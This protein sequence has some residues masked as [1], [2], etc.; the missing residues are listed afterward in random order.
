MACAGKTKKYTDQP[1]WFDPLGPSSIDPKT[2]KQT[3]KPSG[4]VEQRQQIFDRLNAVSP[5]VESASAR[6]VSGLQQAAADPGW[7]EAADL[8]RRTIAGDYLEG[9]PQLDAAM[10]QMRRA[11]GAQAANTAAQLQGQYARAGMDFS[12]AHQQAQQANRAAATAATDTAE[13]QARLQ[14][15][16]SERANQQAGAEMLQKAQAA[17]LEY[18]AAV[19]QAYYAPMGQQAE[20][21]TGLS[22]GGQ[23]ATPSSTMVKQPGAFDYAAVVANTAASAAP[24][25]V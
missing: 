6:T 12:T 21:V 18:L 17:P 9:S 23:V 25:S 8:A 20:I 22:G 3:F 15:Y 10:S 4:A 13:T 11:S 24:D 16:I 2:G 19:P 1:Q 5:E 14:N 7:A